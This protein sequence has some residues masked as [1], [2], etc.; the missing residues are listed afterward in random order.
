MLELSIT[1]FE[2]NL[3]RR[4]I[5]QENGSLRSPFLPSSKQIGMEFHSSW[6]RTFK[7][8]QQRTHVHYNH[9]SDG[10]KLRTIMASLRRIDS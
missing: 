10:S 9:G 8:L 3:D 6:Q 5:S 2:H 1:I 4:G 7:L